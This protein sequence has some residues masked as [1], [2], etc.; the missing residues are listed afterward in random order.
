MDNNA[1]QFTGNIPENYDQ[2]LGPMLFADYG[3]DIA[4]RAAARAPK[5]VLETA[6]GTGI[7]TR[8]LRDLLPA[9]VHL[10]A[11]DL[12]PPM[13]EIAR[14][15]F[16]DG[17]QVEIVPADALALPFKDGSFDAV[18]CQFGV[19]FFPDKPKSYAEVLRVLAPGG[20]Y[21]FNVWD[22][23]RY[24]P[25][26]R[27]AHQVAGSFFPADPPQFFNVPFSYSHIDPIKEALIEAGFGD[28]GIAVIRLEKVIPDLAAF[29]RAAVHGN[30]L[31]DQILS[32]GGVE[33]DQVVEALLDAF[34]KE[35]GP[36]PSRMPL[37]AI[38]FSASKPE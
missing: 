15:K 34:R 3:A 35:F 29:A 26:G 36:G 21:L 19:M 27:I 17:E 12:N 22:S 5:R 18:V 24:N 11:T 8:H 1:A 20:Q 23:H 38:M 9:T 30:P 28:I 2:G 10:T 4:R 13:L 32:R 37:Q 7:V 14:S 6:A 16:R 25:F 33:P 31:A